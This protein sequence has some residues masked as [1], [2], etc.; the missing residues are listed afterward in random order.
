MAQD[1]LLSQFVLYF[2]TLSKTMVPIIDISILVSYSFFYGYI[3][4]IS[5]L[6]VGD[7]AMSHLAGYAFGGMRPHSPEEHVEKPNVIVIHSMKVSSL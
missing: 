4:L 1:V 6:L 7:L 5:C 3:L 2:K